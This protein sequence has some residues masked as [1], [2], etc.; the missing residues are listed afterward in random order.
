MAL[1]HPLM[2]LLM[3]G[4]MLTA[5]AGAVSATGGSSWLRRGMLLI[6]V[7]MAGL[8]LSRLLRGKEPLW[9]LL[10]RGLSV[11]FTAGVITWSIV[12]FGF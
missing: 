9:M 8:T 10:I 7:L 2:G 4:M 1:V 6:A 3:K 12:M 5:T 11:L